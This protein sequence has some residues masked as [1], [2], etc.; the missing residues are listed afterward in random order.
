MRLGHPVLPAPKQT[1]P[2]EAAFQKGPC[3]GGGKAY[4]CSAGQRR[5]VPDPPLRAVTGS[6]FS[7]EFA[8]ENN[9]ISSHL[10]SKAPLKPFHHKSI[11]LMGALKTGRSWS[12]S[13]GTSL[14]QA[15]SSVSFSLSAASVLPL[16]PPRPP[17]PAFLPFWEPLPDWGP[18]TAPFNRTTAF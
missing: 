11:H 10:A 18:A 8:S 7:V 15:L 17:L 6:F 2:Q 5:R 3:R 14:I 13:S 1:P 12:S 9:D 16:S 4:L